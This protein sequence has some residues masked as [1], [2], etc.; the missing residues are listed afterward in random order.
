MVKDAESHAD[1]DR[2]QLDLVTAR[3]QADQLLHSVRKSLA[4]HGDKV[5]A[6]EKESIEA[7]AKEL[8]AVLKAGDK[9]TIEAKSQALATASQK[10]GERLYADAQAKDH[11]GGGPEGGAGPGHGPGTG[12]GSGS[13]DDGNVVDAEYTEVN[14]KKSA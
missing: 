4:E 5:E 3:N 8:E 10:L 6:G 12:S 2:R 7:A 1:E 14:D 13:K 9:E 11:P